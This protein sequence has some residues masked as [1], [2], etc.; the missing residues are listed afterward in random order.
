MWLRAKAQHGSDRHH[1]HCARRDQDRHGQSL[2]SSAWPDS[3]G[4]LRPRSLEDSKLDDLVRDSAQ[5]EELLDPQIILFGSY[6]RDDWIDE[7]A[8]RYLMTGS[9]RSMRLRY[10]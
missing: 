2:I 4:E 6:A 8:N 9:P 10:R 1:R 7:E 5:E 3:S